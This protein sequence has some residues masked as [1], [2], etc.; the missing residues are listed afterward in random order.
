MKIKEITWFKDFAC[1]CGKCPNS[2]CRGW[3][4]PLSDRDVKRLRSQK[5]WLG[6]CLFFATGGWIRAKFNADSGRCPFWGSDSL[7]RLQKK[8][9]HDFLPWTC[10]SYPRFYRN[11]GSVE[12]RCLDLSCPGAAALFLKNKGR[13]DAV[14]FEGDPVTKECTTNDD[15]EYFDL[16][17]KRRSDIISGIHEVFTKSGAKEC[18]RFTDRLFDSAIKLQDHYARQETEEIPE[19]SDH[20]GEPVSFPLPEGVF[21][22]FLASPLNHVRLCKVSPALY[23]M[24][25]RA[26]KMLD[27]IEKEGSSIAE[28]ACCFLDD[29]PD[30]REI[31][32]SYLAY[33]IFQYYMRVFETYSFRRQVALGLCHMNMILLLAM[34]EAGDSGLTDEQLIMIISVY[35]RRAYFNDDI[36]DEM[37]RIFEAGL[38]Q[39]NYRGQDGLSTLS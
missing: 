17:L 7:C 37:Y 21:R 23:R 35:N 31:L 11:F 38:K 26:S 8:K 19:S 10:Q 28:K 34:S 12:E 32:G 9:G 36:Q 16:L 39:R 33:Y 22:G 29:N 6:L 1:L 25:K 14:G 27:L 13:L 3:V 24:F 2:C 5:G 18:G 4:I 30:I 20:P 15:W